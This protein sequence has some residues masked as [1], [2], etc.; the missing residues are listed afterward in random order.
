[1]ED[2]EVD[3]PEDVLVGAA[4]LLLLAQ[5]PNNVVAVIAPIKIICIDFIWHS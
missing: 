2:D 1:M 5:P 3:D 4:G